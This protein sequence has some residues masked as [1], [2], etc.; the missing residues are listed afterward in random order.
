MRTHSFGAFFL[1]LIFMPIYVI[2]RALQFFADSFVMKLFMQK[3]DSTIEDTDST[4]GGHPFFGRFGCLV[5]LGILIGMCEAGMDLFDMSKFEEEK[6]IVISIFLGF[7]SM[8]KVRCILD[9]PVR[10]IQHIYTN[11]IAFPIIEH[12]I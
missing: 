11:Y 10:W 9:A 1:S 4:V 8:L 2:L 12:F 7:M 3:R 5:L 6:D